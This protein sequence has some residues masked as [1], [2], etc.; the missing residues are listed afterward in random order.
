MWEV[1]KEGMIAEG[2][3]AFFAFSNDTSKDKIDE[4]EEYF[5]RAGIKI[6]DIFGYNKINSSSQSRT[7]GKAISQLPPIL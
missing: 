3:G 6:V 4:V 1:L 5:K 2:N 7:V